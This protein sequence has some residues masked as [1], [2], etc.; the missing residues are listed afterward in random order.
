MLFE[1]TKIGL[2]LG[3][4]AMITPEP[5]AIELRFVQQVIDA[6]GKAGNKGCKAFIKGIPTAIPGGSIK[7][8]E[9]IS[10]AV[11]YVVTRYQLFVDGSELCL[12]DRLAGIVRINGIDYMKEVSSLL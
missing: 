2:D 8:G 10:S 1:I 11:P 6:D 4:G 12:I 3:L 5:L 9:S 7:P